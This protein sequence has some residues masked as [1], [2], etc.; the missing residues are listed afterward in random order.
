MLC[1]DHFNNTY[2]III[3]LTYKVDTE[4]M[5]YFFIGRAS[6]TSIGIPCGPKLYVFG[7]ACSNLESSYRALFKDMTI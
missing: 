6:Q 2:K 5:E 3:F 7:D 4:K 1:I